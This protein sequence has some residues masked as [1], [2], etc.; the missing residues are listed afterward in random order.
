MEPGGPDTNWCNNNH[1]LGNDIGAVG[2]LYRRHVDKGLVI[3]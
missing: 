3:W 1:R 2:G